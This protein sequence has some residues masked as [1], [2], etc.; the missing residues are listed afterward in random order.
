MGSGGLETHFRECLGILGRNKGV[1]TA[2]KT[3]LGRRDGLQLIAYTKN[4]YSRADKVNLY[5]G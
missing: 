3:Y 5:K 2:R 4:N 1:S